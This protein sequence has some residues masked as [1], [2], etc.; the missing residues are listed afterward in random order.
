M[1]GKWEIRVRDQRLPAEPE[2]EPRES[3]KAILFRRPEVSGTVPLCGFGARLQDER[4]RL[5]NWLSCLTFFAS[6]P[7]LMQSPPVVAEDPPARRLP[8][9]FVAIE[10][11]GLH[12]SGWPLEI[13]CLKDSSVMT[14]VPSGT[15]RSGLTPEQLRQLAK[16]KLR[17]SGEPSSLEET[18]A[19]D[20]EMF[21]ELLIEGQNEREK[22]TSRAELEELSFEQLTARVV[23]QDLR[24][25][26]TA[27]PESELRRWEAEGRSLHALLAIPVVRDALGEGI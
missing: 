16:L 2:M 26:D 17:L 6:I 12:S 18:E 9:G 19:Q 1:Y 21:I 22:E 27:I 25:T 13:R 5:S 24:E 11:P 4:R 10:A 7:L 3:S 15:F 20:K 14:F 23:L 8:E